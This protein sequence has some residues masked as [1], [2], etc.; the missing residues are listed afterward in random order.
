MTKHK[1]SGRQKNPHYE[2]TTWSSSRGFILAATGAA[3]GLGNIW[4]FP[5]MA[6]D[7]GGSAFVIV[8]LAAILHI[9]LPVMV[10][11]ILL[12][13]MGRENP[14]NTISKLA[15]ANNKSPYWQLT[16]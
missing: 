14:I 8:Y 6:G 4:K 15:K 3:V 16:G 10:A 2:H 12:G 11:E 9:G 5:Y 1:K 13:R 7:N